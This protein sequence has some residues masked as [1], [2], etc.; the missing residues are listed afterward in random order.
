MQAIHF[1]SL[2]VFEASDGIHGHLV[3]EFS[4]DGAVRRSAGKDRPASSRRSW[5]SIFADAIDRGT[6][7]S[8]RLLEIP[9]RRGRPILVRQSRRRISPGTPG[10]SVKRI[11]R[12]RDLAAHVTR[13]LP[14]PQRKRAALEQRR[15]RPCAQIRNEPRMVAGRWKPSRSRRA[16]RWRHLPLTFA[17]L[18]PYRRRVSRFPFAR[19]FLWPL[20]IPRRP[21]LRSGAVAARLVL[22]RRLHRACAGRSTVA[23]ATAVVAAT[24]RR[25]WSIV[26]FRRR[27]DARGA[28][29]PSAGTRRGRGDHG[30]GKPRG[31]EPAG[32]RLRHED[33][34][35]AAF[36]G[37]ALRSG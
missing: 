27:E 36:H 29:R 3:F 16:A 9:C 4:G 26:L 25:S 28:D 22:G 14:P 23:V 30:P 13:L 7:P 32:R 34:P 31:A 8:A 15:D 18:L 5:I 11:H 20:A 33:R 2:N 12:E 1:A 21:C 35:A 19:T 6:Q 10:L 24:R 37:H 17:A